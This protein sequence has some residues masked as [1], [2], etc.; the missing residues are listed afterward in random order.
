ME[1][2]RV[3]TALGGYWCHFLDWDSK[4]V[5]LLGGERVGFCPVH[6]EFEEPVR[7]PSR[8][9][10][11]PWGLGSGA[12]RTGPE[13]P[14]GVL[15][16]GGREALWW[17]SIPGGAQITSLRNTS[18]PGIKGG[19]KKSLKWNVQKARRKPERILQRRDRSSES[20]GAKR[21]IK[22]PWRS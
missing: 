21:S 16:V 2:R 17:V 7:C 22:T 8:M 15:S 6:T 14:V 18:A 20:T 11:E 3:S 19:G 5:T 10:K 9:T 4:A 13:R 12:E 1:E